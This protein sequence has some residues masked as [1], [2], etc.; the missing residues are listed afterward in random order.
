MLTVTEDSKLVRQVG[1]VVVS[2]HCLV[3][4]EHCIVPSVQCDL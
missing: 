2:L 4:V 3:D 1:V